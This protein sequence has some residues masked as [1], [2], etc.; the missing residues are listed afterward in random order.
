MEQNQFLAL[1]KRYHT[2]QQNAISSPALAVAAGMSGRKIRTYINTLRAQ[3]HPICSGDAGYFYAATDA[4]LTATIRQ[5]SSRMAEIAKARHGLKKSRVRF[6]G[7][8]Q[9]ALPV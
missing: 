9:T 3:G 5:L 1:L 8:E 6:S 2:G 4:E 7:T